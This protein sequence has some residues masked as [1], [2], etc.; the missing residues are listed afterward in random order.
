MKDPS[1]RLKNN[2]RAPRTAIKNISDLIKKPLLKSGLETMRLFLCSGQRQ[3]DARELD[4]AGSQRKI[5]EYLESGRILHFIMNTRQMPTED[6]QGRDRDGT[7]QEMFWR[8]Y[9][10][11]HKGLF[12]L[13]P[14]LKCAL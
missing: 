8:F 11:C 2:E 7:E 13:I 10:R 4:Y 6:G 1:N 9:E 3:R 14:G 12:V 5:Q